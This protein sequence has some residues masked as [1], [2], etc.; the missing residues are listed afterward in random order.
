M[1]II[2]IEIQETE[3]FQSYIELIKETEPISITS[4]F[5]A[6]DVMT[7]DDKPPHWRKEVYPAQL[8]ALD[9]HFERFYM[10]DEDKKAFEELT[11]GFV[12]QAKVNLLKQI[13]DLLIETQGKNAIK[14]LEVL[15]EKESK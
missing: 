1:K 11:N 9:E 7:L 8:F 6:A 4:V 2:S 13:K 3:R 5:E 15:I 10:R 14:Y 12:K